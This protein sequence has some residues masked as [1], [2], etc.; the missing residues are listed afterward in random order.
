MLGFHLV[1]LLG[2][3]VEVLALSRIFARPSHVRSL[4]RVLCVQV[5]RITGA[6]K[7][8][9]HLVDGLALIEADLNSSFTRANTLEVILL[10]LSRNYVLHIGHSPERLL[11]E[12]LRQTLDIDVDDLLLGQVLRIMILLGVVTGE[13]RCQEGLLL[14]LRLSHILVHVCWLPVTV[15]LLDG[16]WTCKAVT[17]Q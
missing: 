12:V 4:P 8:E 3:G 11:I 15:L 1:S 6:D 10:N 17:I 9:S 13:R 16:L 7:V 2:F 14:L 5:H